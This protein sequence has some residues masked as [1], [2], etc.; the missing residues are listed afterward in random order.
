MAVAGV[1]AAILFGSLG[2]GAIAVVVTGV[3][4]R[5]KERRS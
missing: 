1:G 3:A 5:V 2:A 4:Y